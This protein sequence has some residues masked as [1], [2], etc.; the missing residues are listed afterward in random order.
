MSS[1]CVPGGWNSITVDRQRV[2]RLLIG[3]SELCH[4]HSIQF[5][6]QL[7]HARHIAVAHVRDSRHLLEHALR[8]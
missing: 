7:G 1:C 5:D 3:N 8:I 4:A 6:I 2:V